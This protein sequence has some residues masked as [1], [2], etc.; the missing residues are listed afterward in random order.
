MSV[1]DQNH[2]SAIGGSW[3]QT[4]DYS[5]I[6]RDARTTSQP[7][8][9]ARAST[10]QARIGEKRCGQESV[11]SML[12]KD[13]GNAEVGDRDDIAGISTASR[14]TAN[15][16]R[17]RDNLVPDNVCAPAARDRDQRGGESPQLKS[18]DTHCPYVVS[19]KP[20]LLSRPPKRGSSRMTSYSGTRSPNARVQ[21]RCSYPFSSHSNARSRSPRCE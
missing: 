9:S 13:S 10:G 1:T 3:K 18:A 12:D 17:G 6:G 19:T 2:R 4:L 7:L 15:G 16:V 8:K 5:G 11:V 21:S 20:S 14:R